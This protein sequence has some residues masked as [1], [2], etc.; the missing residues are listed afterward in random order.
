M[1]LNKKSAISIAASTLLA[2]V[3]SA[4]TLQIG[5]GEGTIA[6]ELF[7]AYSDYN[8]SVIGDNNATVSTGLL[9]TA[10][11]TSPTTVSDPA[12]EFTF[13]NSIEANATAFFYMMDANTSA[14]VSDAGTINGNMLRF[15]SDATVNIVDGGYYRVVALDGAQAI[16]Y[17]VATSDEIPT[18]SKTLNMYGSKTALEAATVSLEVY[19][20]SGTPKLSDTATLDLFTVTPEYTV[21]CVNKFNNLIDA[22]DSSLT[23]VET[24]NGRH[25]NA[26][27]LDLNNTDQM[28]FNV[29]RASVDY[30]VGD[31]IGARLVVDVDANASISLAGAATMSATGW[32]GSVDAK[33]FD[34]N[35]TALA[36]STVAKGANK[37]FTITYETNGTKALSATNFTATYYVDFADYNTTV[38]P[39]GSSSITGSI[40][41]WQKFAYIAQIG[42]ATANSNIK[43]KLFITNRSCAAVVPQFTLVYGGM[44]TTVSAAD[45]TGKT[46]VAADSQVIYTVNEIA[47]VAIANGFDVGTGAL[48]VEVTVPGN[49]EDFYVYAQSKNA[50]SADGF[51]DLPVYNTSTRSY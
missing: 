3:L 28:V 47:D 12:W 36:A 18:T 1:T 13:S 25:A 29:A 26:V 20:M 40:G 27:G 49:P 9:H 41:E 43:T 50:S 37:D 17:V 5:T 7:Q 2:S 51:K 22:T 8:V 32:D 16:A 14:I 35:L 21:T 24:S 39:A 46:S 23:F 42:G 31:N 11:F 45:V 4:G 6:S 15:T 33:G 10:S 38:T 48:S 44:T 30:S 19:S 34:F